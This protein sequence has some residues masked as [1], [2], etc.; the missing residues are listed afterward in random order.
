MVRQREAFRLVDLLDALTVEQ[1]AQVLGIGRR[2]AYVAAGNGQI[3]A[4]RIGGRLIVPRA[5]L[6]KMLRIELTR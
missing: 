6:A 3:P 2:Q 5:R 1:A 4:F